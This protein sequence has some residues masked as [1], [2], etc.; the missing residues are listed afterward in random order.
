M[1]YMNGNLALQPKRKPEQR[2]VVKETTRVMVKRKPL[3][4]QE[5]LLYLCTVIIFVIVAGF[6]IFK[7]AE[8]YQMNLKAKLMNAQYNEMAVDLKDLQTQVQIL[9]DPDRIKEIAEQQGMIVPQDS[10]I[11]VQR[12]ISSA[13]AS[14]TNR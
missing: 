14:T 6:F 13:A 4:V 9:S 12:S 10:S 1:A 7:H 8:V 5:K 2:Q 11:K 3:P